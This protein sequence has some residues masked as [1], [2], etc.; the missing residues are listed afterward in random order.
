MRWLQDIYHGVTTKGIGRNDGLV[1]SFESRF[2]PHGSFIS[3]ELRS[4]N[5]IEGELKIISKGKYDQEPDINQM[6]DLQGE[7]LKEV[8]NVLDLSSVDPIKDRVRDGWQVRAKGFIQGEY[9]HKEFVIGD[10]RS[11]NEDMTINKLKQCVEYLMNVG[12][13]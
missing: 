10:S 12:K 3:A 2:L 11:K 4:R 13:T 5:G 1:L 6:T 7:A 9:Y 8:W